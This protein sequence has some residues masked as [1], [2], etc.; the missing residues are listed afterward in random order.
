[1]KQNK[2]SRNT[3]QEGLEGGQLAKTAIYRRAGLPQSWKVL[4]LEKG[5]GKSWNFTYF[6]LKSWKGP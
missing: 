6:F 4:E 5:P 1:M 3:D 2:Y